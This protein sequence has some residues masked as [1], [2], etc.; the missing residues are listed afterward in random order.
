MGPRNAARS[1]SA[2]A[3]AGGRA[4]EKGR[5]GSLRL[6]VLRKS[7]IRGA[8]RSIRDRTTG[9]SRGDNGEQAQDGPEAI[10][11]AIPV[12]IRAAITA[13]EAPVIQAVIRA[14]PAGIPV[15]WAATPAAIPVTRAV[16]QATP[17]VIPAKPEVIQATRAATPVTR[18]GTPA[19]RSGALWDTLADIPEGTP[20]VLRKSAAVAAQPEVGPDIAVN[21]TSAVKA[22][23]AL[24]LNAADA[25][26]AA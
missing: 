6:S 16:I 17:A 26:G 23:N 3:N 25:A 2:N 20:R 12:G 13:L 11:A 7:I 24:A 8:S 14:I 21:A 18:A 1:A 22:A 4:E 15:I 10:T 5:D 9:T 19:I